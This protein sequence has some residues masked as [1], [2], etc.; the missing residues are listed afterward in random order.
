M[1]QYVMKL[2]DKVLQG[3][4]I[5]PDEAYSLAEFNR[6]DDLLSLVWAGNRVREKFVGFQLDLCAL[7]NAKSG[8]CSEDCAFCAQ[9]SQYRTEAPVHPL[10]SDEEMVQAAVKAKSLGAHR[11]CIVTSG[12]MVNEEEM[13]QIGKAFKK[14]RQ[15]TG[16]E[17]DASLGR[18]FPEHIER[19]K[20][21]GVTRYNHNLETAESYFGQIVTTHRYRDRV[22]TVES[23]K[24]EGIEV[25]CG[26]I[27]GLGESVAQRLDLAFAL[28]ALEVECVPINIL[29]PRPGTPLEDA[30]PLPPLEIVKTIA[31]FRL[32]LPSSTIKLAGGR[33]A[34]LR[35]LQSL[36]LLAGANGLIIGGYLTTQGRGWQE[37]IQMLRDLGLLAN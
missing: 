21:A 2:T 19:L 10:I 36:A 11:F 27:I 17:L 31:I 22:K 25:C 7:V 5:T 15:R 8:I 4:E 3:G 26:G 20:A 34:N 12:E 9:S 16:M 23:L 32:I 6:L 18:L 1:N 37:D 35:D 28:K 33:E 29:N 24:K 13:E 30:A 14:I